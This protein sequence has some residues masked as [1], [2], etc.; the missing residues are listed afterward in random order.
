MLLVTTSFSSWSSSSVLLLFNSSMHLYGVFYSGLT[1]SF[2]ATE[3]FS[4]VP[5]WMLGQISFYCSW[6]LCIIHFFSS[7]QALTNHSPPHCHGRPCSWRRYK[8]G[9]GK[10]CK[11]AGFSLFLF[12]SSSLFLTDYTLTGRFLLSSSV[13]WSFF[14]LMDNKIDKVLAAAL[15]KSNTHFFLTIFSAFTNSPNH[16]FP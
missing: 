15:T 11:D 6:L 16:L 8:V 12:N 14:C 2:I 3:T 7:C 5:G 4:G 10:F 1:P 9:A 13:H